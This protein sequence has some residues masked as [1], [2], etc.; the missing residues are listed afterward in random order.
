MLNNVILILVATLVKY[1]EVVVGYFT[2]LSNMFC[3]FP[4]FR[5]FLQS[6]GALYSGLG[7]C[8]VFWGCVQCP[9]VFPPQS[10][11]PPQRIVMLHKISNQSSNEY[12]FDILYQISNMKMTYLNTECIDINT[13]VLIRALQGNYIA[14]LFPCGGPS[15]GEQLLS[16][17]GAPGARS[18]VELLLGWVDPTTIAA[19]VIASL[20]RIKVCT[21]CTK[22]GQN[23]PIWP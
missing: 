17:L 7:L 22:A 11:P 13:N 18:D 5:G 23:C 2:S 15:W 1:F 8:I 10:I 4:I 16:L 12:Q 21:V 20:Q 6:V 9:G 19:S 3:L 14:R